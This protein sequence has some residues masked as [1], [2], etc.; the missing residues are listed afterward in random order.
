MN[1]DEM[2][3]QIHML[4]Q[5]DMGAIDREFGLAARRFG[6]AMGKKGE[7]FETAGL[8]LAKYLLSDAPFG[9]A[10]RRTIALMVLGT[11]RKPPTRPKLH[12]NHPDVVSVANRFDELTSAG[13]PKDAATQALADELRINIKTVRHRLKIRSDRHEAERLGREALEEK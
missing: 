8:P 7:D 12:P 4:L 5:D 6:A 2:I 9:P 10:E 13:W 3:Q 1:A 11:M